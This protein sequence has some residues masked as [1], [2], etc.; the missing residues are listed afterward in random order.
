MAQLVK[1]SNFSIVSN[2]IVFDKDMSFK[3]KGVYLYLCSRPDGWKFYINEISSNGKDGV[4]SV[5]SAIRELQDG[6]YLVRNRVNGENGKFDYSYEIFETPL[7]VSPHAGFPVTVES[8]TNNTIL[9][10]NTEIIPPYN[11]PRKEFEYPADFLVFW[12]MYEK[13]GNKRTACEKW[14]QLTPTQIKEIAQYLPA[15]LKFRPT[16]YRKN[17]ETYLNPKKEYWKDKI[18][19]RR[20]DVSCYR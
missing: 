1:K 14:K 19:L 16:E 6:G 4:D 5:R 11:T 9:N 20:E 15:Y 2:S 12:E 18:F 3:A 10:N 8:N 7:G 17:A 13:K